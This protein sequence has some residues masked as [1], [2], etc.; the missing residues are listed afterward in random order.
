MAEAVEVENRLYYG[1]E[2]GKPALRDM[3]IES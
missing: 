2:A 3:N 1:V